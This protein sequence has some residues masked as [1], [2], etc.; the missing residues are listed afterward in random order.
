MK[1]AHADVIVKRL[2]LKSPTIFPSRL[3][4]LS[5]LLLREPFAYWGSDGKLHV[6]GLKETNPRKAVMNI[7]KDL[8]EPLI[9][10][11]D[12]KKLIP[13]FYKSRV[14][15]R[16]MKLMQYK[17]IE[18]NI[19]VFASCN[20]DSQRSITSQELTVLASH[21]LLFNMPENID[22]SWKKAC[23][24]LIEAI[25]KAL[26]TEH[27]LNST[28]LHSLKS[29]DSVFWFNLFEKMWAVKELL[30]PRVKSIAILQA[31]MKE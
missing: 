13:D 4:V 23:G 27:S 16:E 18:A 20:F 9:I 29:W 10:D 30:Q 3:S 26:C 31:M 11:K 12:I 5:H 1:L 8:Q 24:E 28:E 22:N 15:E 7:P 17:Y 2:M 25:I 21:P 6:D 19:D 14:V